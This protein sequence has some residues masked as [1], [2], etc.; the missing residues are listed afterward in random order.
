LLL[1]L[2]AFR[3]LRRRRDDSEEDYA[4][5]A[6]PA[7]APEEAPQAPEPVRTAPAPEPAPPP[8]A[9]PAPAAAEPPSG[10]VAIQLRPWIELEFRPGRAAATLTEA[11]VHYDLVVRNTGNAPARNIRLDARM[12]NAGEEQDVEAFLA[13]PAEHVNGA[14]IP[15]IAPRTE[16]LLRSSFTMPKEMVREIVV[17][18]RKLFVPIVAFNVAYQWGANRTGQTATSYVVGREAESPSEKMGGFRTDLGPRIY[19]SVGQRPTRLAR[20]V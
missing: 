7:D 13:Q 5:V 15:D 16:T 11:V 6:E 17:E 14:A 12:F 10:I 9:Q 8:P 19:R 3:M 2:A 20:I 18:G 1:G 4:P